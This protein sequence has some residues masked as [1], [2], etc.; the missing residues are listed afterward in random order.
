MAAKP[1]VTHKANVELIDAT[2]DTGL[3]ITCELGR[4]VYPSGI[5]VSDAELDTVE[6]KSHN[7][8][9]DWKHTITPKSLA[10][11]PRPAGRIL[12]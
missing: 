6:L 7:L 12:A 11:A 9:G 1:L 4:D 2:N 8:R 10:L 5:K 3:R